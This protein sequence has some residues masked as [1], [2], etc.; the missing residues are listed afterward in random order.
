MERSPSQQ[1]PNLPIHI[2]ERWWPFRAEQL[3]ISVDEAR[4]RDARIDRSG[5]PDDF[6]DERMA[7]EAVSIWTVLCNECHGGRRRIDDAIDMP[8]PPAG[9]GRG[10][11]VFFGRTRLRA[12]VFDTIFGGG[13][14]RDGV[15]SEMPKWGGRLSNEQIW[16][17]LYFVEF[18][19]GGA[20][21]HFPPSLPPRPPEI[22]TR[23]RISSV[24]RNA[25]TLR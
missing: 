14:M 19:S 21:S 2:E 23:Q 9:W 6:W 3:G 24:T 1:P 16:A 22:P 25:V 18:Q 8:R 5:P 15:P 20:R 17:L 7:V 12:E 13:P 10:N 11:G 4:A